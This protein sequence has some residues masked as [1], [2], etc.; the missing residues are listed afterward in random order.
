MR[1]W[2]RGT[3]ANQVGGAT[4]TSSNNRDQRI[5]KH[6]RG[7]LVQVDRIKLFV[8]CCECNQTWEE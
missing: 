2:R 6:P 8:T 5:T 4:P 7:V 3:S 1:R